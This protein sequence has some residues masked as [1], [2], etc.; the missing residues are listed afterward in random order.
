MQNQTTIPRTPEEIA[1]CLSRMS[2]EGQCIVTGFILGM[3]ERE[4][5]PNAA[6]PPAPA[7]PVRPSA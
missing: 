5:L 1:M 7:E 6:Q 2:K 3:N 4:R